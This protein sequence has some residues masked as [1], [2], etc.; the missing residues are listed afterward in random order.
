MK[1]NTTE[2]ISRAGIWAQFYLEVCVLNHHTQL[3]SLSNRLVVAINTWPGQWL[4]ET[5]RKNSREA[6]ESHWKHPWVKGSL[7]DSRLQNHLYPTAQGYVEFPATSCTFG[8]SC[9]AQ[10]AT[11]CNLSIW[12]GPTCSLLFSYNFILMFSLDFLHSHL[13]PLPIGCRRHRVNYIII[14]AFHMNHLPYQSIYSVIAINII[15]SLLEC[16]LLQAET[17][18]YSSLHSSS[19]T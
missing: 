7:L 13:P 14:S 12:Q 18:S 4:G 16:K 1:T 6:L 8:S 11:W 17:S 9:P 2:L 10:A 19:S 15:Y 3:Q 5:G